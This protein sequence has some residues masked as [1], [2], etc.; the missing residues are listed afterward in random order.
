MEVKGAEV[1]ERMV[2]SA[3]GKCANRRTEE[4]RLDSKT[5]AEAEAPSQAVMEW[6]EDGETDA[7]GADDSVQGS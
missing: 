7:V 1:S 4:N 6:E 2:S 5:S 3:E